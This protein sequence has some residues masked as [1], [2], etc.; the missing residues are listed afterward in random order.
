MIH[1]VKDIQ[2]L[3]QKSLE[4]DLKEIKILGVYDKLKHVLQREKGLGLSAVQI[5]IPIRMFIMKL[6]NGNLLTVINPEITN[7]YEKKTFIKEGCLSFPN[8]RV[9]TLRYNYTHAEYTDLDGI[10][11]KA[12]LT[13]L[14]SVIFQHECDH[15]NGVLFFDR[16]GLVSSTTA[17]NTSSRKKIG[18]NTP[19]PCG[20]GKKYKRCCL[21]RDEDKVYDV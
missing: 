8:K 10:R 7:Q 13:G 11:K 18:R 16:R 1:V 17:V 12:I 9:N 21:K 2:K 3:R 15:L 20:S 4:T 5:G 19:C 6:N 14:E